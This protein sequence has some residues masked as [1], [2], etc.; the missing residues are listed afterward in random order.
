MSVV[1]ASIALVSLVTS[2]A[3]YIWLGKD[4]LQREDTDRLGKGI[5][6]ALIAWG[7]LVII[8][9]ATG[10]MYEILTC[11]PAGPDSIN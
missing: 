5:A 4:I 10:L 3:I 11:Q 2:A 1:L 8:A 7:S 6:I 9:I